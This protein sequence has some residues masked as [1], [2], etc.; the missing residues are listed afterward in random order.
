MASSSKESAILA[1]L[2]FYRIKYPV[3]SDR[4]IALKADYLAAYESKGS[5]IGKTLT[6]AGADSQSAGWAVSLSTEEQLAVMASAIR[7]LEGRASTS[8]QLFARDTY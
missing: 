5:Q 2:E 4:I 8:V 3:K 6:S 1:L 7:R